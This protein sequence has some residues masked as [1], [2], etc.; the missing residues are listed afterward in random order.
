VQST[1]ENEKRARKQSRRLR[2]VYG[3]SYQ[4]P[5]TIAAAD[6]GG[7][8]GDAAAAAGAAGVAVMAALG[9]GT[10]TGSVA[11]VAASAAAAAARTAAVEQAD[12]QT[13]SRQGDRRK[14]RCGGCGGFKGEG[15]YEQPGD[16]LTRGRGGNTDCIVLWD[17][18]YLCEYLFIYFII[19]LFIL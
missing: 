15:I 4:L 1:R 13:D 19:I 5:A 3:Y 17:V 8:G 16:I 11:S 2:L 6:D 12:R 18:L 14:R 10:T 7:G 9:S